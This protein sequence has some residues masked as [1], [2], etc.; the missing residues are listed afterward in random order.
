MS[1]VLIAGC[2]YVGTELGIRLAE[3]GHDVWGLKRNPGTLPR[4]YGLSPLTSGLRYMIPYCRAWT[5]WSTRSGLTR[6]PRRPTETH[7]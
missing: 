4:R 2:G 5:G 6:R 3:A 1:R 7:M